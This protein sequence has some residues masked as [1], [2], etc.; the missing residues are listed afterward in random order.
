MDITAMMLYAVT[1]SFRVV[2]AF[3]VHPRWEVVL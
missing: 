1:D 2:G 3:N